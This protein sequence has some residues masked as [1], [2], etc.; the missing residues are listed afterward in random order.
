MKPKKI[1]NVEAKSG[2]VQKLKKRIKRLENENTRLKSEVRTLERFVRETSAY[3]DGK[4]D[5]IPVDQVIKGVEKNMKLSQINPEV[6]KE[7]CPK[8][9]TI[10]LKNL[11]YHTGRILVCNNC[12]YRKNVDVKK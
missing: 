6:I 11:P 10:E 8:C 9:I 7:I 1:P 5:G 12:E 4:L 3:V 2:E